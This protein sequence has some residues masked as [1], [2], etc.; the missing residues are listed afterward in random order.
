MEHLTELEFSMYVDGELQTA[1]QHVDHCDACREQINKL[2]VEKQLIANTIRSDENVLVPELDVPLFKKPAGFKEFALVNIGTGLVFWSAQFLWKTLFGELF[3]ELAI[4]AFA[5]IVPVPIPN[6]FEIL[7]SSVLFY[8]Q[9]GTTMIDNYLGLIVL[10]LLVAG[11]IWLAYSYKKARAALSV[12]LL[13]LVG[14]S[15]LAP[16]QAQA[17][18]HRHGEGTITIFADE[19]VNDSLI[20]AAET[21]IVE[22]TVNG[23]LI[24]FA[25]RVVITGNVS[26]NLAAFAESDSIQGEVGGTLVS[27]AQDVEL[28]AAKVTGDFWGAG[29][30]VTVSRDA[31]VRGNAAIATEVATVSG[32]ISRDLFSFAESIELGGTVGKTLR[33]TQGM[34]IC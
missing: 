5:S 17:I 11:L 30:S 13:S 4:R 14:V 33:F 20:I 9:G 15:A 21:V 6:V 31:R 26:G 32:D 7:V 27:F 2:V 8:S 18:E 3:S 23:D 28:A 34:S 19:T 24:T 22:G 25:R 10:S 12:C 1:Q 16:Q 29:Q